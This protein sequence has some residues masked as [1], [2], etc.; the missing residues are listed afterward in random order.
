[1]L[2]ESIATKT[3]INIEDQFYALNNKNTQLGTTLKEED[4]P[5]PGDKTIQQMKRGKLALEDQISELSDG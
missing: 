3:F 5:Q 4:R 1:M 2:Q